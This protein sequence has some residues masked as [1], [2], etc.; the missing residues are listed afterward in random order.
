MA[1]PA[2]RVPEAVL[3]DQPT[4][5]PPY[6]GFSEYERTT[7]CLGCLHCSLRFPRL[8]HHLLSCS[9]CSRFR[10]SYLSDPDQFDNYN[11]SSLYDR[12]LASQCML[13]RN[14]I[15][16]GL[17]P[18]IVGGISD[19]YG[20][21]PAYLIC[22]TLVIAANVGLALQTNYVALLVLRSLQSCGSSGTV[23]LSSGTVSDV[24]TRAER[25]RY[26]G[27]AALG[28]SLGP[29]LGPVIGGLLTHF[30]GWRSIFW[31]LAIYGGV[32]LLVFLAFIPET[33]RNI[34]GNG[35]IPPQRW[36]I[37]LMTYLQRREQG[38]PVLR[39]TIQNKRRPGLLSSIPIMLE[40]EAFLILLFGGILYAGFYTILTGL[41]SQLGA[42][43]NYNPIQVGLCY[44]P[45]GI[46]AMVA[47]TLVGRS[48]DWNFR[49][50]AKQQ[51]LEIVHSQQQDIANFPTERA[52]L[53]V[54]LPCLYFACATIVPY[55]WVVGLQHPPLAAVL[56][57]LFFNATVTSG[58][59]QAMSVLIVDIHP[60]SPAAAT[61]AS[62]L[63][64]CLLGAGG[65]AAV[66]PLLNRIGRGWTSTLIALVWVSMS[67]C[68]WAV[69]IWGPRWR[70]ARKTREELKAA[71][72][73]SQFSR[74]E[75]NENAEGG[76]RGKKE[77]TTLNEEAPQKKDAEKGKAIKSLE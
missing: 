62:N 53:E 51:G 1:L 2:E 54:A 18:T 52:R 69:M 21:R 48:I 37:S 4:T 17:A 55:G 65:V 8:L 22:F 6:S 16:Q 26:I 7:L 12:N 3:E 77:N 72:D 71:R 34:V 20:R 40:K 38:I 49:R 70:Q 67:S 28:S 15:F 50:H 13:I 58:T 36:N 64:R 59:F 56:V 30:L 46:G 68:W 11:I 61:A 35:S 41:P 74:Y 44:I 29:A 45:L 9:E 5:E 24:A 25:G 39:E 32:M 63:I 31:F 23:V 57:L 14:Q 27:L 66:I 10:S 76:L 60:E 47:K 42:T 75:T 19:K 73:E 33:C 43:Y